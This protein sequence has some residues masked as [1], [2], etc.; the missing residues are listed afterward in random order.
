[1]LDKNGFRVSLTKQTR[2]GGKDI[3]VV[4][5]K[6]IGNHLI[7]AECKK[8][9]KNRPVGVELVRQLYGTVVADRATAGML[10][11]SSY[12]TRDAKEFTQK[13]EH[14][15]SLMD[16]CGLLQAIKDTNL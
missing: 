2:D 5:N 9:D 12:F 8:Y 10:I 14:Q 15:M 1:M 16:Y 13:I 4:E 3:I 11:T 6:I 7:Y